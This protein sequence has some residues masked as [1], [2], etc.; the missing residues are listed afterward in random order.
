MN[1]YGI[2]NLYYQWVK[3]NNI[4]LNKSNIKTYNNYYIHY[5]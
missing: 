2:H 1:Y 4:L 5:Y 3:L